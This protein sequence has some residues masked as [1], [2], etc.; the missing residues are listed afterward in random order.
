ME[1]RLKTGIPGLDDMTRGG[2]VR[3]DTVLL[4][5]PPGTGKTTFGLQFLLQGIRDGE[6]GVF[7]TVEEMPKKIVDDAINFGWDLRRLES[8]NRLKIF[9]LQSD[10]L[11]TGGGPIMQCLELVRSMDAK[12]IVVDPISLYSTNIYNMNELRREL[13]SFVNYMKANDVSLLM[14]HEV[15]DVLTRVSKISDY[16]IEFIVDCIIMLQYVEMES[17]IRRSINILKMR[18]SDHDKAIRRYEI[19]KRGFEVLS[20]FEGYEGI[21]S[22][23]ARKTGAQAFMEA[24]KK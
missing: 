5:G 2:F 19:T 7:V 11:Q 22:G 12:R 13:Y 6:N 14:T 16:G 3:G 10:M 1:K 21:M 15:P 20:R 18:G 9:Q 8:E 4:T 23:T 24:F 17:E